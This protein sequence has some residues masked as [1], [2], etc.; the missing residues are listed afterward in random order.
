VSLSHRFSCRDR[1]TG[2]VSLIVPI[3]SNVGALLLNA[4]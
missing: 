4:S 2:G 1:R 3:W